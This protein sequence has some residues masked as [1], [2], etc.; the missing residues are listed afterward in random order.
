[1]NESCLIA[2]LT[3]FGYKDAYVATMK[4]VILS[5]CPDARLVDITPIIEET[6]SQ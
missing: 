1:M 2:I 4:G 5:I 3:D 6:R